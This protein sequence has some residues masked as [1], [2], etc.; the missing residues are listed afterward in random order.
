MSMA[1]LKLKSVNAEKKTICMG[2]VSSQFLI[3]GVRCPKPNVYVNIRR[4]IFLY[5]VQSVALGVN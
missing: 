1:G 2:I 5:K 3:N 4:L